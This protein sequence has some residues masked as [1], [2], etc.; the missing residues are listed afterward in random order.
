MTFLAG[1][2][3]DSCKHARD[4]GAVGSEAVERGRRRLTGVTCGGSQ[5]ACKFASTLDSA[6]NVGVQSNDLLVKLVELYILRVCFVGADGE[7][8]DLQ[9]HVVSFCSRPEE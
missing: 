4:D 9:S 3:C 7:R 8:I 5:R 1:C 6:E 2:R